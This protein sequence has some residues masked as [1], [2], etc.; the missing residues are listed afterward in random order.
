MNSW[1]FLFGLLL[2]TASFTLQAQTKEVRVEHFNLS[3]SLAIQGYD[4]VSYFSNTPTKGTKQFSYNH[5]GV[6][7]YFASQ[8]NKDTFLKE[9]DKYEPQYGGWCAYAMGKAGDKV[10]I[11]VNTYK[12][13]NGKLYLFYNKFFNNTM[14][15][16]NE[17]EKKLM[18]AANTN[19][20][21][22]IQ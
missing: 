13:L 21:K 11:D 15:T 1:K 22:T 5:K 12:I 6:V 4:P 9:P 18:Q 14:L 3:N 20:A 19:W 8:K 2:I 7:Y 10:S 17:D 16:W